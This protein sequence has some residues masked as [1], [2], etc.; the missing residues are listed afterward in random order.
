MTVAGVVLHHVDAAK[1]SVRLLDYYYDPHRVRDVEGKRKHAVRVAV[2]EL[3]HF[4]EVACGDDR[5]VP[6]GDD[7][8]GE[9][10]RGLSSIR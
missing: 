4:R 1:A 9:C 6:G 2:R 10:G 7:R 8:L 5:V 3:C